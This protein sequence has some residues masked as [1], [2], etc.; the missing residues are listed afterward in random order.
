[1][2]YIGTIAISFLVSYILTPFIAQVGKKQNFVDKPGY[3]K[4]HLDA[5]PNLGGVVIFFGFLLSLLLMVP[6]EVKIK[7]LLS[8]G[9]IILLLG[10]I[11]DIVDLK[12]L[13]KFFI[14]MIPVFLILGYHTELINQFIILNFSSFNLAGYLLYP[15]LLGW[16]L[17]VTN[18]INLIDGLDGLACGTSIISLFTLFIMGTI[19]NGNFL[20]YN[21]C[22]A[23]LLGSMIAFFRF[24]FFPAQIFLGDSG[25]TFAGYMIACLSSLWVIASKNVLFLAIPVIMLA[26]PVVDT[27]F[28]IYRRFRNHQPIFQGDQGHIHHRLLKKGYSHRN[29]V[30][31]L[32]GMNT[33]FC[34][35]TLFVFFYFK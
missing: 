10:V 1:M 9:V 3:R 30:L 34:L 27:L 8:G 28:A 32:L 26:L 25:S 22:I 13:I 18:A 20:S 29:V 12:P 16:I 33:F 4:I 19:Y 23:A 35:L 2:K 21:L 5:I 24:N 6:F 11:D 15:L 17:G 7:V 14:Q 31:F